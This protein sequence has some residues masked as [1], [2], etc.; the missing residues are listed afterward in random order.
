MNEVEC[1][2]IIMVMMLNELNFKFQ[3]IILVDIINLLYEE[4]CS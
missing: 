3:E 1:F 2:N 4:C